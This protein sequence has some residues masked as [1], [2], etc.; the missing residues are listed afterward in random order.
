MAKKKVT[1]DSEAMD[2]RPPSGGIIIDSI[3]VLN[4]EE[5][6]KRH[7]IKYQDGGDKKTL[8]SPDEAADSFYKTFASLGDDAIKILELPDEYNF[9]ITVKSLNMK[10]DGSAL[11]MKAQIGIMKD[12][13]NTNGHCLLTTPF[14]HVG[15]PTTSQTDGEKEKDSNTAG[16]TVHTTAAA[17]RIKSMIDHAVNYLD[18]KRAAMTLE[19]QE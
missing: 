5:G 7:I 18:G 3:K 10:Y 16:Y 4:G 1:V 12:L 11:N 6:A 2:N 17:R 19:E 15:A 14:K 9:D 13:S 8:D